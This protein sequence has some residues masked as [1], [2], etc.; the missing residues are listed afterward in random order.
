MTLPVIPPRDSYERPLTDLRI[1]VTDRCNFRCTFC[2][3]AD[4][5]YT[6]LPRREI[7]SFEEVA[8]VAGI[9]VGLGV[10]KIRLTGGEPL[11][12]AGLDHLVSSLAAIDALEDLALTTN[13][14]LLG[15][16]ALALK[17][18]GLQRVTVS[19]HSLDPEVFGRLNGLGMDLDKVLQGLRAA[20][21]AGLGPIKL[22]VVPV[23][24]V[25]D[26]EV[27][28]LARWAAD[29]GYVVRFIEYMDVGTVNGWDEKDVLS[30]QEI[31]DRIHAEMPLEPVSKD[32][33]GEVAHR[34]R[35]VDNGVEV[36]V[37]P[38]ITEP[39]C[40][41]CSRLRLSAEG[42]LYTC[43]FSSRGHDLKEW[44]R[45]GASDEEIAHQIRALWTHRTDRYSEERT[46]ALRA[47]SFVPAEKVEMFRIGG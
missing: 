47:G 44:L 28:S 23:R 26:H 7:L 30:S 16:R 1:S 13:G 46:A 31:L 18:A 5:R 8:R 25:N 35:H 36:G 17:E 24:G 22:N 38:S 9:C 14:Y 20:R 37:I 42:R 34:Y 40:G 43:L 2:M 15:D 39:F 41:D 6:F 4:Q 19:F 32:H 33:R 27:V 45:G 11:L 21:D 10:R 29:Q 12:R 3:P